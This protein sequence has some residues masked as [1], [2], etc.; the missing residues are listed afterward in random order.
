MR[1]EDEYEDIVV[2]PP[3]G[4]ASAASGTDEDR[5]AGRLWVPDLEAKRGWSAHWV[6]R[7]KP[8]SERHVGFRR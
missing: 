7:E 3:V 8:A 6:Y 4:S 1:A 5:A 2:H